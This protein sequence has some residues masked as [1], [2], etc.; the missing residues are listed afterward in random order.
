M[1]SSDNELYLAALKDTPLLF[2]H[3]SVCV[4]NSMAAF[5]FL[6]YMTRG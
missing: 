5:T 6:I 1:L 2:I 4:M 3:E